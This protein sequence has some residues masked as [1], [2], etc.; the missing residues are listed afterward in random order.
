M[1]HA[2]TVGTAKILRKDMTLIQLSLASRQDL[3][4]NSLPIY[5]QGGKFM[6]IFPLFAPPRPI[7]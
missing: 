6:Q 1:C 5:R 3:A 2:Q 7:A 4:N